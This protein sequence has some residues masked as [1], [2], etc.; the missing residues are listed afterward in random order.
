MNTG[1]RAVIP[2]EFREAYMSVGMAIHRIQNLLIALE[3]AALCFQEQPRLEGPDWGSVFDV[4]EEDVNIRLIEKT[5]AMGKAVERALKSV[6]KSET[7]Q[8]LEQLWWCFGLGDIPKFQNLVSIFNRAA[9]YEVDCL[10]ADKADWQGAFESL[11][12]ATKILDK[13]LDAIW[14]GLKEAL[15]AA[16]ESRE[17]HAALVAKKRDRRRGLESTHCEPGER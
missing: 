3:G 10:I 5:E 9:R 4:I 8:E 1:N 6:A 14:D 11:S 2:D 7:K 16:E 15:D 17:E 12:D 13:K